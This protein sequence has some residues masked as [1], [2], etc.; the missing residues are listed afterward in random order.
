MHKDFQPNELMQKI[1]TGQAGQTL[2]EGCLVLEG[3]AFV[4]R[5]Q[6]ISLWNRDCKGKQYETQY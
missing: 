4:E 5:Q 2:T 6:T 3:G 1:P